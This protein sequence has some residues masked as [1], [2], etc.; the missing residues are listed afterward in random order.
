MD[1]DF[2]L[3]KWPDKMISAGLV[4]LYMNAW[5]FF[6]SATRTSMFVSGFH[7][8][9][10]EEAL[11]SFS[12]LDTSSV[13]PNIFRFLRKSA[14]VPKVSLRRPQHVSSKCPDL[15]NFGKAAL[16]WSSFL[17]LIWVAP[18][19]MTDAA[20]VK[21]SC[22]QLSILSES[23]EVS[24]FSL[25]FGV[26]VK[27]TDHFSNKI[28]RKWKCIRSEWLKKSLPMF[29]DILGTFSHSWIQRGFFM[30]LGMAVILLPSRPTNCFA[31]FRPRRCYV[32][33][34]INNVKF[35]CPLDRQCPLRFRCDNFNY[36]GFAG[37]ERCGGVWDESTGSQWHVTA[38]CI[39]ISCP[40]ATAV[41]SLYQ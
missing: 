18:A 24:R 4:N 34:A 20:I 32:P 3:F 26:S 21:R 22:R 6:K 15:A 11:R 7:L 39:T 30:K 29:A 1:F 19:T 10:Q 31:F 5:I 33:I 27:D 13:N 41:G 28:L 12:F 16:F 8:R 36:L 35:A 40:E 38:C 9:V 14:K 2:V 23:R 37:C 25:S 17:N